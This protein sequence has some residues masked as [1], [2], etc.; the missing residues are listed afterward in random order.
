MSLIKYDYKELKNTSIKFIKIS[1]MNL[2][3]TVEFL[4]NK[5][6]REIYANFDPINE[7]ILCKNQAET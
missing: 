2:T 4:S 1:L 5:V 7:L 3:V 6:K